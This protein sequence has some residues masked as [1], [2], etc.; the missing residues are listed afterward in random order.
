MTKKK[1]NLFFMNLS[2]RILHS[3]YGNLLL[4]IIINIILVYLIVV[5]FNLNSKAKQRLQKYLTTFEVTPS[6]TMFIYL[7]SS[8]LKDKKSGTSLTTRRISK[9]KSYAFLSH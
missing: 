8:S 1:L 9:I 7:F 5:H 2:H 3:G 6:Q 4:T